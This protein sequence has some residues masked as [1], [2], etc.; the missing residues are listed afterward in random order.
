MPAYHRGT[1]RIYM[2]VAIALASGNGDWISRVDYPRRLRRSD[3]TTN[4]LLSDKRG[5]RAA[6][7]PVVPAALRDREAGALPHQ[8]GHGG[9]G[10]GVQSVLVQPPHPLL[11]IRSDAVVQ[12]PID[13]HDSRYLHC[14]GR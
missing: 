5:A 4:R 14:L 1:G 6:G 10:E 13:G 11:T 8:L 12:R 7:S 9:R 3:S 2:A